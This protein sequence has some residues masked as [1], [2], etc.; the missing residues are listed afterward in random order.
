MEGL[1]GF[2]LDAEI[3]TSYLTPEPREADVTMASKVVT[4]VAA[5][6]R[7]IHTE[8]Q[9]APRGDHALDAKRTPTSPDSRETFARTTESKVADSPMLEA[10]KRNL[11][12]SDGIREHET[13][14]VSPARARERRAS[15]EAESTVLQPLD[16]FAAMSRGQ[17][18]EYPM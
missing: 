16:V 11:S 2:K 12:E 17:I 9:Q 18:E 8:P 13:V 5:Y 10:G 4:K 15:I 3:G 7:N 1:M 6:Q 14:P